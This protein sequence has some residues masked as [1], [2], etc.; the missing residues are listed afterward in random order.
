[1]VDRYLNNVR[2]VLSRPHTYKLLE[3]GGLI[4]RIVQ[5][6]GPQVYTRAFIGPLPTADNSTG[7]NS[8]IT[9]DEIQAL[10]GV[11]TNSNS[12]WP[13]PEWYEKSSRYNGEWTAANEAWFIKHAEDIRY[14]QQGNLCGGRLWQHTICIHTAEMVFNATVSGT[15]AHTQSCCTYLAREWPELWDRFDMSRLTQ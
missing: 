10:L 5:H 9:P 6:Y 14:A 3:Q 8:V 1:M 2:I 11:T 12:F 13:Y 7:Y 15:M 4:W